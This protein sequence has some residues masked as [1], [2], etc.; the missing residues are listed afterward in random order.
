MR[1]GSTGELR[2][3]KDQL[4][5]L[6]KYQRDAGALD[7]HL[8]DIFTGG[9]DPFLGRESTNSAWGRRDEGKETN[10]GPE[11][12]WD[13]NPSAEPLALIEP[14]DEDREVRLVQWLST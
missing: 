12:C 6:Y 2:Y 9:W 8:A 4:V 14:S 11:I 5:A 10:P 13:Q 7:Q 3:T 1:N